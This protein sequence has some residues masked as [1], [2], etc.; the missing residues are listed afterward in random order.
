MNKEE[1]LPEASFPSLVLMLATGAMQQLGLI[2]NPI[3]KKK[4]SN[5]N[6]AKITIDTLSILKEKTKGNLDKEEEG[7]LDG[8]L[9]DL[10]MK[11]VKELNKKSKEKDK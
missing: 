11:Y 4:E 10:R 6:L 5:L 1:K 3:T 8:L 7:F 2:E 9:Y